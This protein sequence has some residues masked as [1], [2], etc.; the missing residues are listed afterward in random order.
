VRDGVFLMP[1]ENADGVTRLI[2]FVVAP[3]MKSEVLLSALRARIDAVFLPRPLFF[4]DALAAQCH[5]K[6]TAREPAA[7]AQAC[8]DNNSAQWAPTRIC[9]GRAPRAIRQRGFNDERHAVTTQG[10]WRSAI[11]NFSNAGV[12]ARLCRRNFSDADHRRTRM[13]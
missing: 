4:V 3:T 8:A 10:G 1:D 5:G 2:A 9:P 6:N 7:L 13:G 11:G 12:D